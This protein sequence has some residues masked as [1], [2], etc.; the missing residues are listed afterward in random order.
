M[1]ITKK[2][3]MKFHTYISLFFLPVA[4]IYALTGVG[5]IFGFKDNAGANIK[6]FHLQNTVEK[7]QEKEFIINFLKENQIA[8]PKNTNIKTIKDAIIMGNIKYNISIVNDKKNGIIL[9][10][11]NRSI[12][13]VMVLMHKSKGAFYFDILAIG[14]SIS[15]M[16]FYI[17]GL[18]MTSLCSHNRKNA[19][20]FFISGTIITIIA[21]WLSI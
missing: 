19:F 6:E 21:I 1:K 7:G 14:F 11:T 20:G 15:L 2:H 10:V 5:Y 8:I 3:W 4:I 13:G 16:L 9:R 17:S 12:Y 18:I